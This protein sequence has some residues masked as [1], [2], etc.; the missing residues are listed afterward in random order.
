ML[1]WC[2]SSG[3]LFTVDLSVGG[4]E[5]KIEYE[6]DD[7]HDL[8]GY[9]SDDIFKGKEVDDS[10]ENEYESYEYESEETMLNSLADDEMSHTKKNEPTKVIDNIMSFTVDFHQKMQQLYVQMVENLHYIKDK[11]E[12]GEGISKGFHEGHYGEKKYLIPLAL[13][14]VLAPGLQAM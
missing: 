13:M 7:V 3:I 1:K 4:G 2:L 11:I 6:S 8:T 12:E 5:K 9:E 14:G 10:Q